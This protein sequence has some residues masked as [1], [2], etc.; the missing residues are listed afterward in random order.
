VHSDLTEECPDTPAG[1]NLLYLETSG[2]SESDKSKIGVPIVIKRL[3]VWRPV[4]RCAEQDAPA[5]PEHAK[6][7]TPDCGWIRN[8][9]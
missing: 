5:G 6:K 3:L 1:I 8:M 2:L 9:L 4:K 7:F